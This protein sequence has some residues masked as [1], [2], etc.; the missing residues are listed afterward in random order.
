MTFWAV[1]KVASTNTVHF[2]GTNPQGMRLHLPSAQ[3]QDKIVVKIYYQSSMRLQVFVG[4]TFVEDVN[5]LD[6]KAKAQ[7]VRDGRLSPNDGNGYTEQQ[8]HLTDACNIGGSSTAE[9]SCMTPSNVHGANRFN[10]AERMLEIVVAAHDARSFI[11]IQSMPVVAV[12]MGVST[13]V[14]DFYQVKDS[15]LSNLAFTLGI[16]VK[17]IAI[18]DVVAGNA[19]RRRNLLSASTIVNFEVEPAAIVEIGTSAVTVLE[20]IANFTIQ[21]KR[22][23][24]ILGDCG[25]SYMLTNL[26]SDTAVP[27]VNFIA[28]SG[29]VRFPSKETTQEITVQILSEA[30]YR[31]EDLQF[32]LT[33]FDAKNAT[34]GATQIAVIVVRNVHMPAPAAPVMVPSGTSTTAIMVAWSP[35]SWTAPPSEAFNTT[36]GWDLECRHPEVAPTDFETVSVGAASARATLF[37]GL[38]TYRRVQCRIR[39]QAQGGWSSWSAVSSDMYTLSVCGDGARHGMEK[40]DDGGVLGGDGCSAA[41]S[42]E[43]GYACVRSASGVDVCNDGCGN[44]TVEAGEPCDDGNLVANDGCDAS[45]RIEQGW[46]CDN[47]SPHSSIAGANVSLCNVVRGDGFRVSGNEA[48]DDGNLVSGDGCSASMTIE[49]GFNCSEDLSGKS[50]CKN[51]GNGKL[52]GDETCDDA[53]V[54]QACLSCN[55]VKIGWVCAGTTCTAGPEQVKQPLLSSA[56]QSSLQVRWTVPNSYGLE[57]SSYVIQWLNTSSSNWDDSQ[58]ATAPP[59]VKAYTIT[60]LTS[61]TSYKSRIR[62]CTAERCGT[63][64]TASAAL[65]T[66]QRVV[67]LEEIGETVST[68]AASA[69]SSSGV[70]LNGSIGV[71]KPLPEPKAPASSTELNETA[72]VALQQAEVRR[73]EVALLALEPKGSDFAF[74][75]SGAVQD[76]TVLESH[77]KLSFLVQLV[78]T[79]DGSTSHEGCSQQVSVEWEMDGPVTAPNDVSKTSGFVAFSPGDVNKTLDIDIV[80]N[81]ALSHGRAQRLFHLRL[82]LPQGG[83]SVLGGRSNVTVTISDNDDPASIALATQVT[84][85]AGA[86][87]KIPFTRTTWTAGA[88]KIKYRIEDMTAKAREDYTVPALEVTLAAGNVTG[89]ISIQT[90]NAHRCRNVQLNVVLEQVLSECVAG[91]GQFQC[92]GVIAAPQA[93]VTIQNISCYVPVTAPSPGVPRITAVVVLPYSVEEFTG[94]VLDGFKKGVAAS[95]GAAVDDVVINSILPSTSRRLLLRRLLGSG[96]DVDFSVL[97]RAVQLAQSMASKLTLEN[98]NTNLQALGLQPLSA[99]KTAPVVSGG[100]ELLSHPLAACGLC[101]SATSTAGTCSCAGNVVGWQGACCVCACVCPSS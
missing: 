2:T 97:V 95:A 100:C 77:G 27:G 61:S 5:R 68:A 90:T 58:S 8:I 62:A 91:D 76:V 25:M 85:Q 96:V 74:G 21:V 87:V 35:V 23:V 28:K 94:A 54:S 37:G 10:R 31:E 48:C 60:N 86:E 89:N 70:V 75:F 71:T 24:N 55:S 41:C 46:V 20:N 29:T 64:S 3:T 93:V 52:E 80:D 13:S 101:G 15:F 44:G 65:S 33:I 92:H 42:V 82:V 67:A 7:L 36:L 26:S 39:V 30:G 49:I 14:A 32:S 19:R 12:S 53:G 81:A 72:I 98:L 63:Y 22:S 78:R 57:I 43:T 11:E 73:A 1:V 38:S 4:S 69:A 6:G 79:S 84:A 50:T 88:V 99:V 83:A 18:V 45:C 17:R 66:L 9:I 51:C 47:S 56:Q 59:S 40:C 34:L 16:D